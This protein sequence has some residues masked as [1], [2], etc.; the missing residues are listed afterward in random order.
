MLSARVGKHFDAELTATPWLQ[1][2]AKRVIRD[3]VA[4]AALIGGNVGQSSV[5]S[6]TGAESDSVT[7]GSVG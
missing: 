7:Y 1:N 2:S 6:T 5:S 4:A 3:M